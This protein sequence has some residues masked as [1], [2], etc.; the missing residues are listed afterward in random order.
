MKI[1]DALRDTAAVLL[2]TAPVIYY[3]E[4]NAAFA[5]VM[6]R[7]LRCCNERGILLVTTPITLAECLVHPIRQGR[8][9][10]ESAFLALITEGENTT[11]QPIGAEEATDAARLRAKY[12]LTLADSLQVATALQ[13]NCQVLLTNDDALTKVTEVRVLTVSDLRTLD[14]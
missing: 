4:K 10:L 13:A 11:F 9:D 6:D 3:L 8:L 1:E 7:F 14:Q 12:G 2:D 5:P